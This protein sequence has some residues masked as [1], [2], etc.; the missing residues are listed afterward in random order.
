MHVMP[1]EIKM[2][3]ST[4]LPTGWLFCNGQTLDISAYT[5]LFNIIGNRYGGDGI[6]KFR[7]PDYRGKIICGGVYTTDAG[8]VSE[9][10]AG[11]GLIELMLGIVA[12]LFIRY[13]ELLR[14]CIGQLIPSGGLGYVIRHLWRICIIADFIALVFYHYTVSM[15]RCVDIAAVIH[16]Y[17]VKCCVSTKSVVVRLRQ[18]CK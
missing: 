3:P 11:T 14:Y 17:D 16:R 7:L 4:V 9:L 13:V 15:R 2:W 18:S 1:G 10:R 6:T 8:T 5:P 12:T